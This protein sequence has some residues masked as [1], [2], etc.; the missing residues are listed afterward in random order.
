MH[1]RMA[2]TILL[3]ALVAG[4]SVVPAA[5]R[6]PTPAP[7]VPAGR[8]LVVVGQVDEQSM[9]AYVKRTGTTPAGFM[10]YAN[11]Y[12]TPVDLS[13]RL[14]AIGTHL[15]RHP[16]TMLNLGLSFGSISTPSPPHAA[17]VVAGQ[18][19]D[20]IDL[21]SVWLNDLDTLV[22]LRVG[23][24]FDLVGGQYGPPELY[25]AAY[26]HTVDRLRANGVDN[27]EYVWH[28]AGAFWRS[29]DW[30]GFS[31]AAGTA[32]QSRGAADPM[33]QWAGEQEGRALP[34]DRFYPGDGYVDYFAISVW[35]DACCFGRSS[36]VSR[37]EYWERTRELLAEARDMGLRLQI[38]ESTPAY[39]GA[40]SGKASV[41][42]V[43]R[44][45]DLVEEFDIASTALIV[46]DWRSD[47]WFGSAHWGG[48]W[49][50]A[51]IYKYAKVRKAYLRR[52]DS[53]RYVNAGDRWRPRQVSRA[54]ASDSSTRSTTSRTPVAVVTRMCSHCAIIGLP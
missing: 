45:F 33:I 4:L 24:E 22:H 6:R 2:A 1:R 28:S 43:N 8:T 16:G 50:D 26:R 34:I 9:D 18:L 27:V 48:Y 19:D 12:D 5:A 20:Q 51:R 14:D 29:V 17:R 21:L 35:G 13:Y 15:R 3:V 54:K 32:D 25:A 23:Y 47:E 10:H 37:D 36:Q 30:S 31:G 44:Y 53:S 42:W 49:P 11:L 39:V 52:L 46:N 41:K 38:G 40:N 7:Q